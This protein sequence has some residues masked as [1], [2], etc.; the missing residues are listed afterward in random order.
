ML[1]SFLQ[2]GNRFCIW[3]QNDV[4]KGSGNWFLR[5]CFDVNLDMDNFII[6]F[7]PSHFAKD[8]YFADQ[9]PLAIRLEIS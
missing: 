4:R 8:S 9:K 6:K 7:L 5:Q 1:L 2:A 3:F